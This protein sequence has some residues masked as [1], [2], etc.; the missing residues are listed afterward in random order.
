MNNH[1]S[2][3]IDAKI[4][5]KKFLEDIMNKPEN[6][7]LREE[8]NEIKTEIDQMPCA[9][10]TRKSQTGGAFP[11]TP[12]Q[13]ATAVAWAGRIFVVLKAG[14]Y[15]YNIY[16]S[17]SFQCQAEH[18]VAGF[19]GLGDAAYCA[20]KAAILK[21]TVSQLTNLVGVWLAGEGANKMMNPSGGKRKSKRKTRKFKK[22]RKGKKGKKGRKSRRK[23]DN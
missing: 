6:Q 3:P 23:H 17:Y 19:M 21:E 22:T 7:A 16:D 8:M 4:K 11:L 9:L 12:E 15:L 1:N 18:W 20:S 5:A 14:G 2:C 13:T 10:P